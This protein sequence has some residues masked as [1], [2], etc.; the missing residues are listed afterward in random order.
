MSPAELAAL[1]AA[2]ACD[3]LPAGPFDIIYAD[4]PWCYRG[5]KQFGFAGDV[6]VDSGGA[7][8]QYETLSVED[9]CALPVA[10]IC[11]DDALLYMWGTGPMLLTDVPRVIAA[12][13]FEYA[14]VA[15]VWDKERTN[16]G[17]YTLSQAEFC[18][19]AKRGRIPQPRGT[20]NERQWCDAKVV[21]EER[22]KHSAKP[23][24]VRA[25]IERMHPTQRRV[26]L[27]ARERVPGWAG[28]GKEYPL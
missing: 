19:A 28:W 8:A 26:E 22:G 10:A 1:D 15:F 2:V 3:A 23:S 17:Y 11:A 7:I 6:G 14:T 21:H 27:F 13:G 16:P 18:V 4:P 25:R 24:E 9:L 5:K 20:R 12:W